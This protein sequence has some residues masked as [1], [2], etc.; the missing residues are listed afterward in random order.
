MILFDQKTPVDELNDYLKNRINF[1]NKNEV[2]IDNYVDKKYT[3][4]D[5]KT[6]IDNAIKIVIKPWS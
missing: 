6:S 3:K 5:V 1:L 4:L 2:L